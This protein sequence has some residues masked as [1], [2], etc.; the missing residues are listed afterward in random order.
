MR[1][2]HLLNETARKCA[3]SGNVAAA[4]KLL[5]KADAVAAAPSDVATEMTREAMQLQTYNNIG[6]FFTRYF[7]FAT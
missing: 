4:E 1:L 3:A 5:S 2:V 7:M 6:I